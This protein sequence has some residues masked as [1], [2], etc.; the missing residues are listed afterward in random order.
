MVDERNFVWEVMTILTTRSV[1]HVLMS[2]SLLPTL[3]TRIEHK[4]DMSKIALIKSNRY[5]APDVELY[6]DV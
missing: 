1:G 5:L 4:R 6:C 2:L 3:Y